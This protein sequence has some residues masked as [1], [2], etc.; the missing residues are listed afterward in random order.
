VTDYLPQLPPNWWQNVPP[1]MNEDQARG[2]LYAVNTRSDKEQQEK[3]RKDA[4][5]RARG[6]ADAYDAE[7]YDRTYHDEKRRRWAR[8]ALDAEETGANVPLVWTT[9][10]ERAARP[11]MTWLVRGLVPAVGIGVAFGRM[12][13]GKSLLFDVD[14]GLS[15]VNELRTWQGFEI[16]DPARRHVG[17]VLMEGVAGFPARERA[18]LAGHPSC[19]REGLLTFEY[20]PVNLG[21]EDFIGRLIASIKDAK[22]AADSFKPSLLIVD[23]QGLATPDAEESGRS[24]MRRVYRLCKRLADALGC[25][26]LLITH[27]G[28]QYS[29]RPAGSS[30]QEQDAD[31]SIRVQDGWLE[32]NKVKEGEPGARRF[33]EFVRPEGSASVYVRHVETDSNLGRAA[34]R[35]LE[36]YHRILCAVRQLQ[37][38]RGTPKNKVYEV[39]GGNRKTF[40]ETLDLLVHEGRL[41]ASSN[42]GAP[43]LS[44]TEEV[45]CG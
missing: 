42:G 12:G 19:T 3:E 45:T 44:T 33:F 36:R 5:A 34:A 25:F 38:T 23:T 30:T 10:D 11:P 8:R 18:W 20:Q 16:A 27:P 24:D 15:L 37:G 31:L 32:V 6:F 43:L 40:F 22:V 29:H 9:A 35:E 4:E 2:W 28:H 13:T 26:V 21:S 7:T 17:V 39:V 41:L 14:L 1:G